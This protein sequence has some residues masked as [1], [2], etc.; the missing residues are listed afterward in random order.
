VPLVHDV[1]G[2]GISPRGLEPGGKR[3]LKA[4]GVSW[5]YE[6]V[7]DLVDR[8]GWGNSGQG[9]LSISG[10]RGWFKSGH[11]GEGGQPAKA[12]LS[13]AGLLHG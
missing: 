8:V 5:S 3:S 7:D 1:R 4:E 2:V 11:G 12:S 9:R 10:G 13:A 6:L